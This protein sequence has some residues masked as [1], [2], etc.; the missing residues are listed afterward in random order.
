MLPCKWKC[1]GHRVSSRR[2]RVEVG[3]GVQV[4]VAGAA[5]RFIDTH[6][7]S[8]STHSLNIFIHVY[9]FYFQQLFVYFD[10]H[11]TV[12]RKGTLKENV[13]I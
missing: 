4:V 2:E 13:Q 1:E 3:V 11:F 9:S 10:F 6:G 12:T 7:N 8:C 5:F